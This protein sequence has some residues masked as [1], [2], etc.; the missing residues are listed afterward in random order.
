VVALGV[1]AGL[2]LASDPAWVAADAVARALA[3]VARALATILAPIVETLIRLLEPI[4]DAIIALLRS[5]ME[6]AGE[7]RV[8]LPAPLSLGAD[9]GQATDEVSRV[10]AQLG[11]VLRILLTVA[12]VGVLLW[13]ALRTTNRPRSSADG[14]E[15]DEF[16]P[17]RDPARGA[18]GGLAGILRSVA[19]WPGRARGLVHAFLVRRVYAQ[20]LDWA[21]GEGRPRRSAETPLEF[22]AALEGLRPDLREDLD[23]ITHAYLLVR[24]GE[25]PESTEMIR[26]V[27]ASWDRVRRSISPARLPGEGNSW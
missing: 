9:D 18:R 4:F 3:S 7:P 19:R 23:A 5:W 1:V 8:V 25:I 21:A 6:G 15:P 26:A 11:V 2:A 14:R 22:G 10:L 16:E 24:Y 12:G 20:L 17:M 13:M 27:L